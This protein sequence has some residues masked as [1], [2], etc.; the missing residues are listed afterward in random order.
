ML[1]PLIVVSRW[2]ALTSA[3][4]RMDTPELASLRARL[5]SEEEHLRWLRETKREHGAD[6]L[7]VD[8]GYLAGVEERIALLKR[9]IAEYGA[10][11][12]GEE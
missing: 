8:A 12:I 4:S 6:G 10:G 7:P 11:I 1:G 2:E 9:R 5:A 3:V